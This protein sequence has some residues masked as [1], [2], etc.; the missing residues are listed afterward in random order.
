M[1]AKI[2]DCNQACS[3][4]EDLEDAGLSPYFC[5]VTIPL[6]RPENGARGQAAAA[7][8]ERIPIGLHRDALKLLEFSHVLI[9]TLFST[10]PA[11]A[12]PFCAPRRSDIDRSNALT[13]PDARAYLRPPRAHRLHLATAHHR[14]LPL[15]ILQDR[16]GRRDAGPDHAGD[17]GAQQG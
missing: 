7:A 4:L 12:L 6:S 2:R 14:G 13:A 10:C 16:A 8:L 11:H 17:R 9:G 3:S 5:S 1:R 15:R